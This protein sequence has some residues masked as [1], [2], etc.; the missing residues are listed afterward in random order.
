MNSE[1]DDN[2]YS[3]GF[4]HTTS[5]GKPGPAMCPCGAWANYLVWRELKVEK[6]ASCAVA[7]EEEHQANG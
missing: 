3:K 5:S 1:P 2:G 4:H 7:E 6:C